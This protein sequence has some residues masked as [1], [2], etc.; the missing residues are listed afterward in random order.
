MDIATTYKYVLTRIGERI[1]TRAS[2]VLNVSINYL[3]VGRW[4]AAK[5]FDTSKRVERREEL[6]DMVAERIGDRVV[7]YLE[8]GVRYG[9][10]MQ[11]WS[12][13]L[14]NPAS[15]L[16]GFD[17]FEGL[18]EQ[19]NEYNP[20]GQ[21]SANGAIPSIN[22]QRVK[23]FK[24]WFHETLPHYE[25]PA[26]EHM[27]LNMDADLYLSTKCALDALRHLVK[28]GTYIYFDEFFDRNHELKA[29][30]EFIGET[31]LRFELVSTDKT[32]SRTLFQCVG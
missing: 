24:G 7:L 22:D 13:L 2:H 18:P 29:F 30:D 14:R 26:H 8:F 16:H 23:F 31:K 17:S 9:R 10:S 27:V 4:M 6:F 32:L 3:E 15:H 28:R 1:S 20:R 21:F 11:Y 25:A 19:W 5:G 12:K